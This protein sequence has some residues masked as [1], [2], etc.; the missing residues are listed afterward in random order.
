MLR[1]GQTDPVLHGSGILAPYI[2]GSDLNIQHC[3][4]D[5]R[6][7]HQLLECGQ[8]DSRPHHIGSK[9]VSKPVRIGTKDLTAQAMMAEQRAESGYSQGLSAVAALQGN[10]QSG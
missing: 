9:G 8:G 2:L 7:S 10:E 3:G 6:V 5:L 4:E 1:C